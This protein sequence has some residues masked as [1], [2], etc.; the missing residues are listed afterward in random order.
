MQTLKVGI[1]SFFRNL[2]IK[3]FDE[4]TTHQSIGSNTPSEYLK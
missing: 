1:F 4:S 3:Q 2:R